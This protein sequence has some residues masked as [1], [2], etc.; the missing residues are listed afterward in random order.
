M[1]PPDYVARTGVAYIAP[2]HPGQQIDHEPG[3]TAAMTMAANR[4]YD[5]AIKLFECYTQVKEALR[6]Q[7]L[8][9]INATYY[10]VMEDATFGYSDV[11]IINLLNHLQDN[12]SL[13]HI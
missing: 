3:A 10:D 8:T 5:N 9:A 6:Q 1:T 2:V 7:I 13:I 11:T 4:A 12:L